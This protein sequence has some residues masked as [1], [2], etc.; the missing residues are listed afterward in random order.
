MNNEIYIA[1]KS[2]IRE[3][4]DFLMLQKLAFETVQKFSG[5]IWTDYNEHDPGVTIMDAFNY[6]LSEINYKMGFSFPD[7]LSSEKKRFS[8]VDFGLYRPYEVYPTKPITSID[9]R[10]LIFDYVYKIND[11]WLVPSQNLHLG[12]IDIIV[13]LDYSVQEDEKIKISNQIRNIFHDNRN[14]G[15]MLGSLNYIEREKLDLRGEI[16]LHEDAD[17]SMVLAEIYF[18]CAK[19]FTPGIQ[20]SNLRDLFQEGENWT[21]ILEGPLLQYGIIQNKELRPLNNTYY[22]SALHSVIRKIKGVKAIRKL[23][24]MNNGKAF[25]EEINVQDPLHS[26]TIR[27]PE[28]KEDV[29]VVPLKNDR[30]TDFSYELAYNCYKKLIATEFG[31]HNRLQ[32]LHNYFDTPEGRYKSLKDYYSIQNDFPDFYGI[33]SK[34]IPDFYPEERKEKARQLKAYLLIFDLLLAYTAENLEQLP[35]L[36]NISGQ[37]PHIPFPDLSNSVS[38]WHQLITEKQIKEV[39]PS[40][41]DPFL[42]KAKHSVFDVLD[43]LY[44][45]KSYLPYIEEYNVYSTSTSKQYELLEQR[46][47]FIRQMPEIIPQRAKSVNLLKEDPENIPGLKKWFAAILGLPNALELPVTNVFSTYSLRLL[48]DEEFYSNMGILN[49]DYVVN[50]LKENFKGESL[51]DI[52]EEKVENPEKNYQEFREKVYLLHHNIIFESLLR[53]GIF[54]SRYK[55]IQT[56]KGVFILTYRAEEKEEWISLGRFNSRAS[57]AIIANQLRLFLIKLNRHSENMFIVEHLLLCPTKLKNGY[58]LKIYD[59]EG[60]VLFTLLNPVSR[61]EI[62]HIK[63]ELNDQVNSPGFFKIEE[64]ISDRFVILRKLENRNAI[65]FQRTFNSQEEAQFYLKEILSQQT[66][67]YRIFYQLSEKIL[68]KEDFPD[69]GITI[70][71]PA[72]SARFYNQKF[73]ILCEELLEERCPAHLKINF[74]WLDSPNMRSF[75]KLYFAW[76][77]SFADAKNTDIASIDLAS[78]LT[79]N[80]NL[81]E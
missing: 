17:P 47:S 25:A 46:A 8:P 70:V 62:I 37:I 76:R 59:T 43:S 13:D 71:L 79:K 41:P 36:L 10:K 29:L 31:Q 50:E 14:L 39:L 20:Y 74:L 16:L 40:D 75:E 23:V 80:M 11:L 78:F 54:L 34:G 77:E 67:S 48:S 45:E 21:G 2:E 73:R 1:Q 66:F 58:T 51:F 53:N 22:V 33:N 30:E 26:F 38:H 60:Q 18:E 64:S 57:A 55:I 6:A 9:Y 15:E 44:G 49:I 81:D 52:Q 28:K 12:F 27:L 5:N 3:E 61:N 65:Y 7:Y 32:N 68:L 63:E 72:W 24:V 19:Y 42:I 4:T 35:V 69:L 56:S